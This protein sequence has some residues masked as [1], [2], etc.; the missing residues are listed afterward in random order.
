MTISPI[1]GLPVAS[2]PKR[3]ASSSR[4][5][6]KSVANTLQPAARSSC[7]ASIPSAPQPITATR[8]PSVSPARRTPCSAIAPNATLL[9]ST[10]PKPTGIGTAKFTGTATT[11]A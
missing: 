4:P 6:S 11:S 8:S 7:N 2:A 5:G 3:R 9:A 1:A 10:K